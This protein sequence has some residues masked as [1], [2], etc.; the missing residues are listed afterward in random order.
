MT[1]SVATIRAVAKGGP[2]GQLPM[3]QN[4]KGADLGLVFLIFYKKTGLVMKKA[5]LVIKPLGMD[6]KKNFDSRII[7]N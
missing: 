3:G 5:P 7:I 6:Q 4:T 1:Q 2:P